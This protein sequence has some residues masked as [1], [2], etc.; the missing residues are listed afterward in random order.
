MLRYESQSLK[1]SEINQMC[2][3][4]TKLELLRDYRIITLTTTGQTP[5][6]IC[7]IL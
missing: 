1:K 5:S 3:N 6:D 7:V 4:H 2:R